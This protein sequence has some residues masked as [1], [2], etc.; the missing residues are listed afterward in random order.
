MWTFHLLIVAAALCLSGTVA[1]VNNL[2]VKYAFL[3]GYYDIPLS[4]GEVERD[5]SS[6]Y[7]FVGHEEDLNVDL[8]SYPSDPR[9]FI[10]FASNGNIAGLRTGYIKSDVAKRALSHNL[11]FP[12]NFDKQPYYTS[13]NYWNTDVWYTTVLFVNPESLRSGK[14]PTDADVDL[15]LPLEGKFTLIPKD[16]CK[17]EALGF[18]KQ[19]C[20]IGMGMH[21]F[22]KLQNTSRCEDLAGV[23]LLYESGQLIGL[24]I[25]PFGSFTSNERTWFEDPPASVI[26]HI[27]P[28]GPACMTDWLNNYGATSIHIFFKTFPRLTF[29]TWPWQKSNQCAK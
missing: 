6:K 21:Y 3:D 28:N 13:G 5:C 8:Y 20:F 11:T 18:T 15:Y 29:C 22:Y 4:K 23:F 9:F 12:Y 16:Q 2:H 17:A 27:A 7:V 25:T 14:G 19:N 26:K 24:G 10:L 1:V